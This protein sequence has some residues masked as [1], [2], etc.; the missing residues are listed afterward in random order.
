MANPQSLP[1]DRKKPGSKDPTLSRSQ[2]GFL[3][4]FLHAEVCWS[5]GALQNIKLVI[6]TPHPAGGSPVSKHQVSGFQVSGVRKE[7]QKTET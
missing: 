3:T 7:R 4:S 6:R 5:D 1:K 2:M